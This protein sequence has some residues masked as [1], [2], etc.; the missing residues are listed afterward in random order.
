MPGAKS[1]PAPSDEAA[2]DAV[3]AAVADCDRPAP[4]LR[5]RPGH[6]DA[7][8]DAASRAAEDAARRGRGPGRPAASAPISASASCSALLDD[9]PATVVVG[10]VGGQG[11]LLGRG[12]QQLSPA[13]LRRVGTENIEVIAGL[14]KLLALEPAVLHVDTGDPELDRAALR[15]PSRPRRP[16]AYARLQGGRVT[17][18]PYMP[19]STPEL[20]RALLDAVGVADVESLF[21]QIPASHRMQGTLELPPALTSEAAL[22]RHLL[23]LLSRNETCERNLSFLGGG[24]WQHHVP[25]DLRRGRAPQRVPDAGLG[26]PVVRP[27]PQPGLVRVHEPARRA[28]RDGLRRP[29]RLQLGLR[30]GP[31][32][33][34]GGA[35]DRTPARARARHD[36][37]GAPRRH[38]HVLRR[39]RDVR[40]RSRSSSSPTTR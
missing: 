19:N 38:P 30:R 4:H 2:L 21:S 34:D 20:E 12:N 6:D 37:P 5:A 29:A 36:E 3:C 26:Y 10:V 1:S 40:A 9:E 25:G 27:R 28:D 39:G 32:G 33:P 24:I 16:A 18:H 11:A 31:R 14:H 22:R 15:L 8:R 7:P 17:A 23:D 13:V 35:P